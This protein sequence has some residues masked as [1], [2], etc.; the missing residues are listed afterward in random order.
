MILTS[1]KRPGPLLLVGKI[2][3][4]M[5]VCFLFDDDVRVNRPRRARAFLSRAIQFHFSSFVLAS[6]VPLENLN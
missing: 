3:R 5:S 2:C 6:I 4:T 1:Q